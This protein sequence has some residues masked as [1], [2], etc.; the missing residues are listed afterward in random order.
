MPEM[1]KKIRRQIQSTAEP[2]T[3]LG[4]LGGV[5]T[6]SIGLEIYD[7]ALCIKRTSVHPGANPI[8]VEVRS[9]GTLKP[10]G[11]GSPTDLAHNHANSAPEVLKGDHRRLFGFHRKSA[12]LASLLLAAGLLAFTFVCEALEPT[13][14]LASYARQSWVMENG[15]PQNT[16]Q[17][18]AQTRDGF[19]WLGTEVGL[20]RFDGNG[21]VLFDQST[22]PALPG[23]DMRCLFESHDGAMWIG[24]S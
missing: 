17:A 20:V 22:S 13:S 23:N 14:P 19:V 24:T 21:F 16:V 12:G 18:L 11:S 5:R 2:V 1:Y 10:W 9:F 8:T 15:L 6:P 4:P 3:C 7:S